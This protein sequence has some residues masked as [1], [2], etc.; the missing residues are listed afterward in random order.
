VKTIVLVAAAMAAA[1]PVL[2]SADVSKCYD[3]RR[4][5]DSVGPSTTRIKL[6]SGNSIDRTVPAGRRSN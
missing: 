6:E 4:A 2:A 3:L 5:V 1:F